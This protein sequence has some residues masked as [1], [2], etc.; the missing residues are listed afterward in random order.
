M[1]PIKMVSVQQK[2]F[3]FCSLTMLF[4]FL[5]ALLLQSKVLV[6]VG[7]IVMLASSILKIR[8]APLILLYQVSLG[9]FIKSEEI[10]FDEHAIV[11]AHGFAAA[12]SAIALVL[13]SYVNEPLGWG[14]VGV[15]ILA[16]T[17]AFF[18]YCGAAKLYSCLNSDSGN[19]CRFGRKVKT[20]C[21]LDK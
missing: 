3:K 21:R 6:G 10:F 12:L 1:I 18:G 7:F 17:S 2:A 9:K 20:T 16:K 5:V 15:L 11:F 13:L 4:I 19:C 14:L 8:R